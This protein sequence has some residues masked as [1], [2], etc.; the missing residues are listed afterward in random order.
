VRNGPAEGA[1]G[2]PVPGLAGPG[3]D[4]A[5]GLFARAP[6]DGVCVLPPLD[7]EF[8]PRGVMRFVT[9]EVTAVTVCET[10]GGGDTG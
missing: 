7:G 4:R 3:P 5:L 8:E 2:E 10:T 9:V 1:L 6:P